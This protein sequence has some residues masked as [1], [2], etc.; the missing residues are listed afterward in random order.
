M[1]EALKPS[2]E[3]AHKSKGLARAFESLV[4]LPDD[5]S[6]DDREDAPPQKRR[7]SEP[8]SGRQR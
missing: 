8:V 3:S 6:G 5:V 7:N 1:Y 4:N 2:R